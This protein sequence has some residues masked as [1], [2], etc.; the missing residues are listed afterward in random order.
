MQGQVMRKWVTFATLKQRILLMMK[1]LVLCLLLLVAGAGSVCGKGKADIKFDKLTHDF[2]TFPES[3][4]VVSCVF[5]FTNTGDGPLVIHQAMA[6]CGCTVPEY[7]EEP[8]LPGKTGT[9]KVTYNGVGRYPGHF[10]KAINVRTNAENGELIRLYIEG[11][12]TVEDED[13]EKEQV[14]RP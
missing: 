2:G 7:T 10:R 1:N 14:K 4:G 12:M 8:V 13:A 3:E 11:N 5:T 9:L 6:T